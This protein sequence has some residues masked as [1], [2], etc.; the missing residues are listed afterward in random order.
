MGIRPEHFEDAG[1][2]SPANVDR[3]VMF[4]TTIDV[5]ESLGSDVYAHF[6]VECGRASSA[7]LGELAADSGRDDTVGGRGEIVARLDAA[8]KVKEEQTARLWFD[9]SKIQLFDRTSGANVLVDR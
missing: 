4:N 2:V 7:G 3:G 5:L 9:A 1:V 6:S 8:T